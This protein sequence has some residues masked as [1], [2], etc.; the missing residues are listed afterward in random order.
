[1]L[2]EGIPAAMIESA[3]ALAGF[4]VGPLAVSDE[5]SLTLMSKIRKQ[6]AVD[7]AAEGKT[8]PVH[9]AHSVIDTMLD[10]GRAGKLSGQGFYEY[11]DNGKKHLWSG[12]ADTF[13]PVENL[14][15]LQELKDRLLFIMAIE[16]ARCLEEDVLTNVNDAN[17]GSIFGIGFPAWTGGALQFI[18]YLGIQE[19]IDRSEVLAFTW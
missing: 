18:N 11:P 12:L 1:M 19:F 8:A 6:A 3:A 13:S 15:S 5:V 10:L 16:T 7:F 4:P 17:I 9:P 2:G 14:P